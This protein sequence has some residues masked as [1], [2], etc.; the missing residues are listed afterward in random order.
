MVWPDGSSYIGQWKES[1]RHGKGVFEDAHGDVHDGTPT[2]SKSPSKQK[3][4]Q[5]MK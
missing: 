1:K 4:M 3:R 5:G 2:S